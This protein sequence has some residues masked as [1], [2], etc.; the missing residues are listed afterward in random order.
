MLPTITR[1]ILNHL[2]NLS[3]TTPVPTL[4]IPTIINPIVRRKIKRSVEVE[5]FPKV[6]IK[7][8]NEIMIRTNP[9][10]NFVAFPM[11]LS[12]SL[13]I[14]TFTLEIPDNKMINVNI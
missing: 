1:K 2:I 11:L 10:I 14:E 12:F 4:A 3:F 13:L 9:E 5:G 8:T 7:I 6:V